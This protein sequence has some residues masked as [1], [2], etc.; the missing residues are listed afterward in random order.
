MADAEE[1]TEW[2]LRLD[3]DYKELMEHLERVKAE[4]Q[5]ALQ[6]VESRA[7]TRFGRK[8]GMLK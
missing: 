6:A 1:R 4:N 5:A 2:A 8:L 3:K 7:W